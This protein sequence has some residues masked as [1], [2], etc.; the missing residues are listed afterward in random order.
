MPR[1]LSLFQ[2]LIIAFSVLLLAA[3]GSTPEERIAEGKPLKLESFD[4]QV[5]LKKRWNRNL[6]SGQG[7][8][9][10][11]L[12]PGISSSGVCIA[13]VKGR[14][15]CYSHE[16]KKQ[17]RKKMRLKLVGGAGVSESFVFVGTSN[18]W[19]IALGREDGAELW[20]VDLKGEALAPAQESNGIVIV[21]LADGRLIGLAGANG[22]KQWEYKNDEPLLTLRGTA[23]P[24]IQGEKVYAGFGN[25]KL[26]ALS[27]SDGSV[28][29]EQLI[30]LAK[31]AA[32]IERIVDIDAAPIIIGEVLYATSFNGYL[33]ALSVRNGAPRWRFETSSYRKVGNGFG[34]V[35]LVDE[36]SRVYAIGEQ[37]GEQNWEQ[38]SLLNRELTAPIVYDG[39]LIIADYDGYLHVFSQVDGSIIGRK[40]INGSGVRVA[41]QVYRGQLYVYANNGELA[42]YTMKRLN[43]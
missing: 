5:K 29:W 24:V 40:R 19:L 23:T 37:N 27:L 28:L 21:Q 25:G 1:L 39:Y 33:Y 31:G 4:R 43:D 38:S 22:E 10:N 16:G 13:E 11:R 30:A 32:E 9:Y 20:R 41:M 6:G 8:H 12:A 35:Y 26:V 3:C 15:A 18:G 34:N 17:W 36:D 42:V 14:V 7:K 2:A